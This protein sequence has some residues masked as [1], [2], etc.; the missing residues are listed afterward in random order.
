MA[1]SGSCPKESKNG[2]FMQPMYLNAVG[3]IL[4][5]Q[6]GRSDPLTLL[7]SCSTEMRSASPQ[8]ALP[9]L[10]IDRGHWNLVVLK[11]TDQSWFGKP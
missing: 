6:V 10:I 7:P 11:K 2:S 3:Q 9:H 4:G 5:V 1:I 8:F